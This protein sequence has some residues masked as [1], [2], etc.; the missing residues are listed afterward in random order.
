MK[1]L[2]IQNVF[3]P[4]QEEINFLKQKTLAPKIRLSLYTYSYTLL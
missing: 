3:Q 2:M 1:F 4:S